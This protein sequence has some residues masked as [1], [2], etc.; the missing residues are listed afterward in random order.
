DR[1][2]PVEHD[3]VDV[4][5]GGGLEAVVERRDVRVEADADVRQVVDQDAD[6]LQRLGS[7]LVAVSV[8]ADHGQAGTSV[9]GAFD[10]IAGLNVASHAVFRGKEGDDVQNRVL[11]GHID[12]REQLFGRRQLIGDQ[13]DAFPAK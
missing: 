3:D 7:R 10:G 4:V 12:Q 9:D 13:A 8:K 2:G 1:V 6:V 5:L 11:R